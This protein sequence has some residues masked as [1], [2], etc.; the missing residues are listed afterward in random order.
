MRL[1]DVYVQTPVCPDGVVLTY[2]AKGEAV[3]LLN[4][5]STGI[6]SSILDLGTRWR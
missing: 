6:H 4:Y 1:Y 3:P 5:L 2:R